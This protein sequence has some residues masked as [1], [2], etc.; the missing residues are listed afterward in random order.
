MNLQGINYA[1]LGFVSIGL[2]ISWDSN[3]KQKNM[4]FPKRWT[5]VSLENLAES[6]V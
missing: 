4:I 2:T 5:S 6:G 1:E 3:K